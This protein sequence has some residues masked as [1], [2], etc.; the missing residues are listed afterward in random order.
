MSINSRNN[1]GSLVRFLALG[2]SYTIGE[3][4]DERES[5]PWV[6]TV[7]LRDE[8]LDVADP[9]IIATTG[10]TTRDLDAAIT[11]A[12]PE[13]PFQLVTLLIGVNNQYQ[14]LGLEEYREQFANLLDRAVALAGGDL[15][16]VIVISVPDWGAAPHAEGRDRVAIAEAIDAFNS[17]ARQAASDRGCA[18]VEVTDLSRL[19]MGRLDLVA[20][21]GLHPSGAMYA[22]WADRILPVLRD[23]L[24]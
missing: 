9:R 8:G 24:S 20:D 22:L 15:R 11:E 2:D 23:A 13:G 6:V 17:V 10:W 1:D 5:W 18:F 21:D 16:R 19:A 7:R 12:A 14:G 3:A 4:V